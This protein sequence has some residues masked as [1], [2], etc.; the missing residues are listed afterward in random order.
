MFQLPPGWKYNGE[1][2]L[3]FL[4]ILLKNF[5]YAFEFRNETWY[6]EDCYQAL[7]KYNCAFC[8]Y[9]IEY[10]LSPIITTANFVYVRL[11]GP[12]SKYNGS[13]NDETLI[14]WAKNCILWQKEGK[15]VYFYFD[16]DINGHAI[17][18]AISLKKFINELQEA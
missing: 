18:N 14:N 13:Y 15:S 10:H 16:N 1:R 3:D 11:H 2:L 12:D 7:R 5:K 6:N 4:K 17:F 8:I 9:E